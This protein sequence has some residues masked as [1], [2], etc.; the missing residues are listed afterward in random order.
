MEAELAAT[1]ACASA[2]SFRRSVT[3]GRG[4]AARWVSEQRQRSPV[5]EPPLQEFDFDHGGQCR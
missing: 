2:T 5:A 1:A 3:Y 4:L